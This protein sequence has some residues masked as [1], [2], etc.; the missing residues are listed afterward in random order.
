MSASNSF[1]FTGSQAG[2]G[3]GQAEDNDLLTWESGLGSAQELDGNIVL[4]SIF[5]SDDQ[6]SWDFYDPQDVDTRNECLDYLGISTDWISESAQ[7]WGAEPHFIYNWSEDPQLYYE[8]KIIASVTAYG[9]DP[10]GEVS[11]FID[12]HVNTEELLDRYEADSIVFVAFVNTPLHKQY[13]S[14]TI[15][16]DDKALSTFEVSYIL[17]GCNGVKENPATYAHEI[18][19]SFGAPDLYRAGNPA[20]NYNIDERFTEYCETNYP[21]DIMLINYDV[22]TKESYY[23]HISNEISQI[24]AYYIGW[25]YECPEADEFDLQ[26]SQHLCQ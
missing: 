18:L 10:T 3:S 16:Y 19:H 17:T 25:T 22:D 13:P 7:T 4:V 15:P 2:Y 14:Y 11:D 26:P 6:N 24:T 20:F 8:A 1:T 9:D 23:D 21:N 12:Q 5:L